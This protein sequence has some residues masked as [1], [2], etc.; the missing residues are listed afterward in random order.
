[1]GAVVV[2]V[3]ISHARLPDSLAAS[4]ASGQGLKLLSMR[5]QSKSAQAMGGPTALFRSTCAE[6]VAC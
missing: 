4:M 3:G 6:T 1:M 2:E 5:P